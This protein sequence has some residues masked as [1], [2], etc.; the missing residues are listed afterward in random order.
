MFFLKYNQFFEQTKNYKP[1][2]RPNTKRYQFIEN[3]QSLKFTNLA[4]KPQYTR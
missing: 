3:S 2:Q 1:A 4:L